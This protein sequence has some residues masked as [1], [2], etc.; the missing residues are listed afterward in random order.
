MNLSL[1]GNCMIHIRQSMQN[2]LQNRAAESCCKPT[3]VFLVALLVLL[4]QV[5]AGAVIRQVAWSAR[6][7]REGHAANHQARLR[8]LQAGLNLE[9]QDQIAP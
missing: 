2:T 1:R 8:V 5:V 9:M 6:R 7:E 3:V 4:I